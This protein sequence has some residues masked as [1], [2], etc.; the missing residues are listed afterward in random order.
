[1]FMLHASIDPAWRA[2]DEEECRRIIEGLQPT[3]N[4]SGS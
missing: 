4:L 3:T 1:M 2:L